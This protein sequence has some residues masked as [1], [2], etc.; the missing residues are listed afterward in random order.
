MFS[1]AVSVRFTTAQRFLCILSASLCVVYAGVHLIGIEYL[2]STEQLRAF[3][4]PRFFSFPAWF[5]ISIGFLWIWPRKRLLRHIYTALNWRVFGGSHVGTLVFCG[6]LL[7]QVFHVGARMIPQILWTVKN[8][9]LSPTQ[10]YSQRNFG[11]G[12]ARWFY[13]VGQFWQ[14]SISDK[15]NAIVG[16]PPQSDPWIRSGNA[17]YVYSFIYPAKT[18]PMPLEISDIPSHVTHLVIARGETD[19]GTGG[20]PKEPIPKERIKELIVF[21]PFT[22][23]SESKGKSSYIPDDFAD[24]Y[25][26]IEL[27]RTP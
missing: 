27:E 1:V 18:Y 14:R 22:N 9:S 21:D 26:L 10:R 25:G 20:W 5:F 4:L 3:Y 19:T 16:I 15:E 24:R 2:S 12:E 7:S 8:R 23:T 6:V 17:Y 11:V 13:A